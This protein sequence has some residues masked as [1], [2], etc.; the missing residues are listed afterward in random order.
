MTIYQIFLLLTILAIVFSM[1]FFIKLVHGIKPE[2][3]RFAGVLGPL[4]I[5]SSSILN[6][7]GRVYRVKFVLSLI[8]VIAL[9]SFVAFL[10]P[11]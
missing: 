8:I 3:A 2:K 7:T 11:K 10:N 9:M 6:D 5:F 4:F 1:Y